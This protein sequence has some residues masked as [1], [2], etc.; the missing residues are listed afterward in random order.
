MEGGMRSRSK[1]PDQGIINWYNNLIK[2]CMTES[3]QRECLS[4]VV[5]FDF[6]N[7][8]RAFL[9]PKGTLISKIFR[10]LTKEI[11]SDRRFTLRSGIDHHELLRRLNL[12]LMDPSRNFTVSFFQYNEKSDHPKVLDIKLKNITPQDTDSEYPMSDVSHFSPDDILM[13]SFERLCISRSGK[14]MFLDMIDDALRETIN[15]LNK[16]VNQDWV[17]LRLYRA[18]V[19]ARDPDFFRTPTAKP[20]TPAARAYDYLFMQPF[21]QFSEIKK[22]DYYTPEPDSLSSA[23]DPTLFTFSAEAIKVLG[24]VTLDEQFRSH[25]DDRIKSLITRAANQEEMIHLIENIGVLGV[26]ARQ[27][28]DLIF[29]GVSTEHA[30]QYLLAYEVALGVNSES[31][32]KTDQRFIAP[33]KTVNVFFDNYNHLESAIVK[34]DWGKEESKRIFSLTLGWTDNLNESANQKGGITPLYLAVESGK[35]AMARELLVYPSVKAQID[36]KDVQG[37][38]VLISAYSA[39]QVNL[40]EKYKFINELLPLVNKETIQAKNAEGD[41]LLSLAIKNADLRLVEKIVHHTPSTNHELLFLLS[42]LMHDESITQEQSL[43]LKLIIPQVIAYTE[44]FDIKNTDRDTLLMCVIK[45]NQ[46]EWFTE[47]IKNDHF[48]QQCLSTQE[49]VKAV[50]T[51]LF[52]QESSELQRLTVL[53]V[54]LSDDCCKVHVMLIGESGWLLNRVVLLL[55]NHHKHHSES[56]DS[57]STRSRLVT[58]IHRLIEAGE[59]VNYRVDNTT[60][61]NRID[62]CGADTEGLKLW[63]NQNRVV[64]SEAPSVTVLTVNDPLLEATTEKLPVAKAQAV[65][66]LR[67]NVPEI[68]PNNQDKNQLSVVRER[69]LYM[70]EQYLSHA[71]RKFLFQTPNLFHSQQEKQDS[72]IKNI[73][74]LHPWFRL[75]M[76]E[77]VIAVN[78]AATVEAVQEAYK[79]FARISFAATRGDD[80][81]EIPLIGGQFRQACDAIFSRNTLYLNAFELTGDDCSKIIARYNNE[82]MSQVKKKMN[83]LVFDSVPHL[84]TSRVSQQCLQ[85]LG[86]VIGSDHSVEKKQEPVKLVGDHSIAD[87]HSHVYKYMSDPNNYTRR[88]HKVIKAAIEEKLQSDASLKKS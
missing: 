70:C 74:S 31:I 16:L 85:A 55:V 76:R 23:L 6:V 82:S 28:F 33:G 32:N 27:L 3:G 51:Q 1:K 79:R 56:Y 63:I 11:S 45:R 68:D 7:M 64:P 48:M 22:L 17:V 13:Q 49:Q 87:A 35:F 86:Q 41:C 58:L 71:S 43:Q 29:E 65:H 30:Q 52:S 80:Q 88:L 5:T 66:V 81:I 42:S 4:M 37:R 50:F 47:L 73:R 9:G 60:L 25:P 34:L 46:T 72:W 18:Y 69:L 53:E 15:K 2:T 39:S 54:L 8:L 84:K 14:N 10:A 20:Y 67:E 75:H 83:R 40:D 57:E 24:A 78:D 36:W 62:Q 12:W 26:D 61:M 59:D 21:S 77:M 38:T 19:L 44:R